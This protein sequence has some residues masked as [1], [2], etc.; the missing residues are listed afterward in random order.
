MTNSI[1]TFFW[2]SAIYIF[3]QSKIDE[4]QY[5]YD[6]IFLSIVIIFMYFINVSILQDKCNSVDIWTIVKSLFPWIFIFGIMMYALNKFPWWKTPFS[7]TF[8][9]LIAK[10]AGCNT[11]F[12]NLLLPQT[13]VEDKL[14]HV[15]T[16]PSLLINKFTL[17]NFNEMISK[18]NHLFD[19][20]D[21]SKINEF[22]NIIKLKEL[23]SE[24]IWY[25]L[26]ASVVVSVS[27]NSIMSSKC[28]KSTSQYIDNHNNAL[29]ENQ[30]EET[31]DL[32]TVTN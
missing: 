27:Y 21:Q 17:V 18:L 16:D 2:L 9:L 3:I 4:K 1:G 26:T 22:K 13:K 29:A 19:T 24:W 30:S 12:L 20:T 32:Y 25:I 28:N 11:I 15:Y 7:N 14:Q 8:G 5:Y 10:F 6:I 23:I 31:P